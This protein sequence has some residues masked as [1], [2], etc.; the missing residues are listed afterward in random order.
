MALAL[1]FE[2]LKKATKS[3]DLQIE[4]TCIKYVL[5]SSDS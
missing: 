1:A 2:I 5:P 3:F 4:L